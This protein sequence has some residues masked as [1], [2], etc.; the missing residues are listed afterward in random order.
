MNR[1][2]NL[3]PQPPEVWKLTE[4]PLES[5]RRAWTIEPMK[6]VAHSG[7]ASA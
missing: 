6:F 4:P 2:L 1:V 3:K 7:R 5:R